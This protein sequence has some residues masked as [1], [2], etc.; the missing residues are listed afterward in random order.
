MIIVIIAVTYFEVIKIM[1]RDIEGPARPPSKPATADADVDVD[2]VIHHNW[3]S[4]G[5]LLSTK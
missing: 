5:I 3:A 4:L 2:G 1:I